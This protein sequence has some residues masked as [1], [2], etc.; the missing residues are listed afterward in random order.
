MSACTLESKL[1]PEV[2]GSDGQAGATAHHFRRAEEY[3][4][5]RSRSRLGEAQ[6]RKAAIRLKLW[7]H[8][9]SA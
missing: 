7:Y 2:S 4:I 6:D 8:S 5:G 3:R 1:H 9:T